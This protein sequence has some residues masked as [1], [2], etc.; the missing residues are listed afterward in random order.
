MAVRSEPP[1]LIIIDAQ[2]G[3]DSPVCGRR[4]NPQAEAHIA[5]L[6]QC[7]RMLG[8]PVRHDSV[9]PDSPLRPGAS[10][11][12]FKPEA[13]P[14]PGEPVFPKTVNSGFIGTNLEDHLREAG[15]TAVVCAGF[16]TDHCVSTTVRM[17]ANLGFDTTVVTDATATHERTA[18]EGQHFCATTMHETA[19]ASLGGEFATL[20]TTQ[21]LVAEMNEQYRTAAHAAPTAL[22]DA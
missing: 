6:L 20:V 19:L 11:H 12:A 16:T 7:W 3:I 21:A 4:N 5:T 2:Q 14:L 15:V 1:A 22:E 18:P 17:A 13:E 8:L 9:S 10:G